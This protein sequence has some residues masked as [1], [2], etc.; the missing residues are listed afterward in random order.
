MRLVMTLLVRDEEDIIRQNI[1]YHLRMGVDYIIVTD[2][3]STDS[4]VDILKEFESQGVLYLINEDQDN[5]AQA[6]WVSRMANLAYERYGA[7]WVINSDAD[8]FW[9]PLSGNLSETLFRIP[10]YYDVVVVPEQDFVPLVAEKPILWYEKMV[11]RKKISKNALG[12]PSLPKVCHRGVANI[13][14]AQGNHNIRWP[15]SLAVFPDRP[16]EIL[17]FP[18]R[19]LAQFENK[20]I[21]G[22]SAYERNTYLPK[23]V[24]RTW[25]KLYKIW[26]RGKLG[27]YYQ[28]Q[29]WSDDQIKRG[30]DKGCL[31]QDTR[32]KDYLQANSMNY[33]THPEQ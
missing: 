6:K 29:V 19:S 10:D 5:Y 14:I 33:T 2:N 18:I 8:E 32:L 11:I 25:R 23:N 15:K 22:G 16:I 24:G 21:K 9:W 26:K 30:I 28:K 1:F 20:I 17:H 31:I 7:D 4:T 13:E 12:R 27:N 3:K